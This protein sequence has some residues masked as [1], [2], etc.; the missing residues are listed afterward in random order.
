MFLKCFENVVCFKIRAPAVIIQNVC[1]CVVGELIFNPQILLACFTLSLEKQSC[2]VFF[3]L[4]L[5]KTE[6][7]FVIHSTLTSLKITDS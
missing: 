3:F 1:G 7:P 2:Y 4:T 5:L 6:F